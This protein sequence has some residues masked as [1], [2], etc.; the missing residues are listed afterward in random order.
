MK[1]PK[2]LQGVKTRKS[3]VG[4]FGVLQVKS[5]QVR[6]LCKKLQTIVSDFIFSEPQ[7]QTCKPA[8]ML[9]VL[10]SLVGKLVSRQA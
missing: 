9:N 6:K 3:V 8:H 5:F 10:K 1:V 4:Y 7:P 2:F